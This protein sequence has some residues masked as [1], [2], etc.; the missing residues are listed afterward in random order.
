MA[1][2]RANTHENP[3]DKGENEKR[4]EG[5]LPDGRW[6]AR[7]KSWAKRKKGCSADF[8]LKTKVRETERLSKK[9]RGSEHIGNRHPEWA[10]TQ[11]L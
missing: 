1:E 11:T 6:D 10:S 5:L 3:D 8:G 4:G 7:N 9:G 2:N